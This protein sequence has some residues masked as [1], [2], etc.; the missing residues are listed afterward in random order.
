MKRTKPASIDDYLAALNDDQRDALQKLRATIRTAAPEAEECISY[1]L[2]AFRQNGV[3]VAFGAT[4]DHCSFFPMSPS[5]IEA[6]RKELEGYETSKGTIRFQADRPLPDALVRNMVK[7]RLAE[8][9]R[10]RKP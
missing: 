10:R 3:L 1:Q 4:P 2:P 9:L 7:A 8:N 5:I 6:H